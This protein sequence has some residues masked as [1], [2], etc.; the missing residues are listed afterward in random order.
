MAD[1]RICFKIEVSFYNETKA[2]FDNLI[3]KVANLVFELS[4]NDPTFIH[5]P[6]DCKDGEQETD[7][8]IA[9]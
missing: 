6:Q 7:I 8:K 1:E 9:N 2:T 5:K 4:E 3:D